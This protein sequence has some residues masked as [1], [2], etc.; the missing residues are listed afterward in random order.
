MATGHLI[1]LGYGDV[2][3]RIV[4]VLKESD[5]YFTVVDQNEEILTRASFDIFNRSNFN[6]VIG[7]STHEEV[8]MEAGIEDVDAVI[9]SLNNDSDTI[10]STLIARSL[11]PKSTI[12]ARANSVDSIDKI[13]KAGADYVASLSIVAGEMLAKI[14]SICDREDRDCMRDDIVLYEGIEI[15]KYHVPAGHDM[16]GST[17]K[18][19]GFV[20]SMNCKVI[21]IEREGGIMTGDIDQ[22]IIKEDDIIAVVGSMENIGV[23]KKRYIM[24]HNQI[25]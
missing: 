22:I 20:S 12:F 15:E 2:G 24:H 21:G 25:I 19:M 16:I 1:V 4:E 6:V 13:Y 23:F 5:A 18:Q 14:I 11:N 8:L 3:K 10:F 7:N 9:I 17:V